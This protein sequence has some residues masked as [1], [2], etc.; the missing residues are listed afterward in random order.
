MQT[1]ALYHDS[2]FKRVLEDLEARIAPATF[3]ISGG[4]VVNEAGDDV[5]QAHHQE[6]MD[7]AATK[8]ALLKKGDLLVADINS[9]GVFDEGTDTPVAEI[10]GGAALVF[11]TDTDESGDINAQEISGLA[12]SDKFGGQLNATVHG[13]IAT[14]LNADFTLNRDKFATAASISKLTINGAV[15]GNIGA[16]GSITGLKITSP[17]G[18]QSVVQLFTSNGVGNHYDIVFGESEVEIATSI[19]TAKSTSISKIVIEGGIFGISAGSAIGKSGGSVKD[20]SVINTIEGTFFGITAGK[21]DNLKKAGSGGSISGVTLDGRAYGDI[22][23]AS[24]DGAM[25]EEEASLSGGAGGSITKVSVISGATSLFLNA[26]G[27]GYGLLKAKGG[28]GGKISGIDAVISN[29]GSVE[30]FGGHGGG[31]EK[32]AGAGGS[33]SS[34]KLLGTDFSSISFEGGEAGNSFGAERIAGG[35][36]AGGSISKISVQST[37][38]TGS[39][40]S[41]RA[42]GGEGGY[43]SYTSFSPN[44]DADYPMYRYVGGKGGKGGSIKTILIS[45]LVAAA[46][47]IT[48]GDGGNSTYKTSGAAGGSVAGVKAQ[49]TDLANSQITG[50]TGGS[51][52]EGAVGPDGKVSKIN[53]TLGIINM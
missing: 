1:R 48:G 50:G 3:L 40:G 43:G 30:F 15:E 6:A 22:E 24:G 28:V 31:A 8:A 11:F 45:N 35:G 29:G 47:D 4:T 20:I 42:T 18:V 10:K 7:F 5:T 38:A 46:I 16:S 27:G 37:I 49:V 36:G 44:P 25:G 14:L 12:V 17:D 23:F 19:S 34:V 39:I 21:G 32:A 9:N 52:D 13:D 51:S 33:I 26:G 41:F 2:L 53:V